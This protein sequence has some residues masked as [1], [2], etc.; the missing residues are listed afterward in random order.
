MLPIICCRPRPDG[1]T[2]RLDEML[3]ALSAPFRRA[4]AERA[5][6]APPHTSAAN[7]AE[8]QRE[9]DVVGMD[10]GLHVTPPSTL[11]RNAAV[12]A[13]LTPDNVALLDQAPAAVQAKG[14]VSDSDGRSVASSKRSARSALERM[15]DM[16]ATGVLGAQ[17]P[18]S[19]FGFGA[20]RTTGALKTWEDDDIGED[21]LVL[22]SDDT[23]RENTL[24]KLAKLTVD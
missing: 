7:A 4:D 18:T 24:D 20:G 10:A 16:Q 6:G 22:E 12:V 19:G 2:S 11:D 23:P 15:V 13:P 21:G 1:K 17:L 14:P 9:R 5:A 3:L 8:D